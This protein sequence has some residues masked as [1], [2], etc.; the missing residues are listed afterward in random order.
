MST[1]YYIEA[2]DGGVRSEECYGGAL[3]LAVADRSEAE[4]ALRDCQHEAD[5]LALDGDGRWPADCY[6]IAEVES[7]D[8]RELTIDGVRMTDS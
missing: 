8:R 2:D 7:D 3:R 5:M 6:H 4:D 1:Y